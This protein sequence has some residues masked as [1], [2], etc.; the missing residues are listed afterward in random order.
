MSLVECFNS[1]VFVAYLLYVVDWFVHCLCRVCKIAV[2]TLSCV[3][4][5]KSMEETQKFLDQLSRY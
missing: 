1:L 4:P 3:F 2:T 5:K